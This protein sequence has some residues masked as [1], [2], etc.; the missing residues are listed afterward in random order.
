MSDY[1]AKIL[2][3]LDTSANDHN[4]TKW[5][6]LRTWENVEN[7]NDGEVYIGIT[8]FDSQNVGATLNCLGIVYKSRSLRNG[9]Y[10]CT[11]DGLSY[12]SN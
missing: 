3:W 4:Y 2:N 8:F 7:P 12:P 5:F 1:M 9:N 6:F 10:T 11:E